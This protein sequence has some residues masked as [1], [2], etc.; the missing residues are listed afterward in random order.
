MGD[1]WAQGA[2]PGLGRQ[3]RQHPADLRRVPM[4]ATRWRWDAALV[5]RRGNA[6]ETRY[7]IRLQLGDDRGKVNS[8]RDSAR[9]TCLVICWKGKERGEV[10]DCRV[11]G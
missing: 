4:P 8:L 5:E 2:S 10:N 7:A 6:V 3:P 11:F 9:G 1:R